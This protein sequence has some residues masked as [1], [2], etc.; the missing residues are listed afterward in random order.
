MPEILT[1]SPRLQ[2][3][4]LRSLCIAWNGIRVLLRTQR[5]ARIHLTST[6]LVTLAGLACH[7]PGTQWALLFLAMGLVWTA[8]GLNTA[9]EFLTDL[10]SPE[11]HP[12]A[13]KAKDVAAGAVLLAACAA[14]G[15]GVCVF[16]P[17]LG[18]LFK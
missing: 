12:L 16:L 8:E 7:L 17:Y 18:Q 15:V 2:Y 11:V 9:V 5:N 1:E 3:S 14:V 13:G 4:F 10:V 6:L